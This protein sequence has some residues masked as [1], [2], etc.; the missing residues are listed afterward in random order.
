M[1]R[2][3]ILVLDFGG[4][5]NQLIARRVRELSV[6]SEVHPH[7]LPIDEIRR[8]AP[9]GIILTGGPASV[10][11]EDS[12]KCSGELF[13]LGIPVLGICYG[14]QLMTYLLGGRV[15]SAGVREYGH[16]EV[17]TDGTDLLF[18]GVNKKTVVWMS[19]TDRITEVAPGFRVSASS[20]SCPIA[21]ASDWTRKL[22]LTQFH[23]EVTHSKE[24]Q[25]MLGNFV[26]NVCKCRCDWKMS[27]FVDSTVE[28]LRAKVGK[29]RV[30]CA[31]SGGVDSSVA[32]VLMSKAVG[33]QLTCVFVDHG[34]LR[35]NEGDDV[36]AV[37]GP[38]GPYEL[39]FIRV[40]AQGRFYEKLKG[41][42][43]PEKKRHIIGEEFIRVF[44]EEARKIGAV[45]FL[46]QGTIY[47][48]V[49][50]SGLGK[51]ATIKSHHNVGG[52]PDHVDFKEII[53]PLR[54]LF[55]D[56]VRRAGL[57]LGIPEKLVYRQPFPGPGLAIRIVGDIT[58]EKVHI[59]Q[60]AD[61][62]FREEMAKAGFDKFAN[63]YF[64][65]LSNMRSVGCM[66]DERTYDYAVV[67]RA[68]TTSDFMTA[69]AAQL[70][71]TLLGTVTNRIVNEVKGVNRVLYDCTGKPPA[72]IELE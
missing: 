2:E 66:G 27:S 50:E 19:H 61:A 58:P 52:L 8:M 35:K 9:S 13:E 43:E 70:P 5:Y 69:E 51:S 7:T 64:A 15:E 12:P 65:A 56:E 63:Q 71:W 41:V 10:Y 6:Y 23:P 68:V 40:N 28:E 72:T 24:G 1:N 17:S 33:K 39:N 55:K 37:F 32:A 3:M 42:T 21:A 4:Q 57:E 48:D 53:E 31:L 34:L 30:L 67:L 62:I 36:E 22:F 45:D 44:E 26:R 49:I 16:T 47:P 20:A 18:T 29:G 46:V 38:R 54:L 25:T 11:K 14:A 60:D 59:V